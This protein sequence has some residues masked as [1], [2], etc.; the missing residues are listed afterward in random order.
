MQKY[1]SFPQYFKT[2]VSY[3]L[4]CVF[5]LLTEGPHILQKL[6]TISMPLIALQL[7]SN[8]LVFGEDVSSPIHAFKT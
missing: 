7:A 8:Y 4:M 1:Y 6:L 5:F 2:H 3:P